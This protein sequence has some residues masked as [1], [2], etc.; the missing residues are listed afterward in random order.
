[1]APH[2]YTYVFV[3]GTFFAMLDA[4]N[5]GASEFLQSLLPFWMKS[6]RMD[7]NDK[8]TMSRTL[9]LPVSLPD[10]SPIDGPWCLEQFSKC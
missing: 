8:Q 7:T 1:M 4:Y 5:N 2:Q 3:I 9:G 10:R 6:G